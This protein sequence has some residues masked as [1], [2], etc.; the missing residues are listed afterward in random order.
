M[1]QL[2]VWIVDDDEDYCHL[3]QEV[4]EDGFDVRAFVDAR[5]YRDLITRER[6]DIVLMDI[7]LPDSSGISLC[8]E[9][10]ESELDTAVIFVSGMNTLEERL[11]AYEAGAVDFIAKPFELKELL[12]KT[13][14][15]GHY[16]AKKRSLEQ[17]ESMSR[18]MAFQSMGES[19]QYGAVL[20]F[21]RQCFLCRDFQTLADAFF[22]LMEQ[23][24]LNTCLEIRVKDTH[25]FVPEHTP[26]SPIEANIFELLDRQGRLYDF[27][28]RTVC[29]DRHVSFLIK[30]MPLQDEVL[31]GRVRDIIAVVVE[32][33]EARVL[34]IQ[35]QNALASL[36]ADIGA[37]LEG[38][39]DSIRQSDEAFGRAMVNITNDIRASFHVLDMTEEQE[40][41]FAALVERNLQ[42]A[43]TASQAFIAVKDSLSSILDMLKSSS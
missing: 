31:Y 27:G 26:I 43:K 10:Q 1:E 25:Y 33:L 13:H 38:L 7:N 22:E 28:A 40:R 4:L 36:V 34:D 20:Q 37:L 24:N 35:R 42:Q 41:F 18:N 19:A 15:V 3:M 11:K 8:R 17:A 30:N 39:G 5:S 14:A 9:L 16:Q 12:A 32:G 2:K 21:F 29:N 6:P 23:L